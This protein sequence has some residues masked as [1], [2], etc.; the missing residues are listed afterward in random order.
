MMLPRTLSNNP[1]EAMPPSRRR[2]VPPRLV[3][4][5]ALLA[6]SAVILRS[7]FDDNDVGNR[8]LL[9]K[10]KDPLATHLANV[11]GTTTAAEA[12]AKATTA[13]RIASAGS[14]DEAIATV[15]GTADAPSAES[16]TPLYWHIY[17]AGGTAMKNVLTQCLDLTVASNVGVLKG[18]DKD[19]VRL[20]RTSILR[21]N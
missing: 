4:A 15:R 3:A 6:S 14:A 2:V 1:L 7:S 5:L 19:T 21:S 20:L 17:K 10:K 11:V 12:I 13:G 8:A 16:V 18:H 9:V